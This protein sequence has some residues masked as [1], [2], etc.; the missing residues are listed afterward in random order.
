MLVELVCPEMSRM[1]SSSVVVNHPKKGKKSFFRGKMLNI[2]QIIGVTKKQ[3]ALSEPLKHGGH[4]SV[5]D[6]LIM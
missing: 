1:L 4:D 2:S 3:R 6:Y 5:F